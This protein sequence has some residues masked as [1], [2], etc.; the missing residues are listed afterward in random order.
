MAEVGELRTV[1]NDRLGVK[2]QS[3][4]ATASNQHTPFAAWAGNAATVVSTRHLHDL[5]RD[6]ALVLAVPVMQVV[7]MSFDQH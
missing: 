7:S 1:A 3:A 2:Y 4:G 5:C 6:F